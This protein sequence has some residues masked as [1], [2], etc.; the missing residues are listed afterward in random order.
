MNKLNIIN[1]LVIVNFMYQLA[2]ATVPIWS[3]TILDVSVKVIL[4]IYL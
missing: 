1:K 3:N 2:C 4:L